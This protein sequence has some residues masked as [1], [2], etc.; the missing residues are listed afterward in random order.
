M[1]RKRKRR[2]SSIANA[3]TRA[4]VHGKK[5]ETSE[6]ERG[7]IDIWIAGEYTGWLDKETTEQIMS[8]D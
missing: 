6:N 2:T 5:I 7:K 1:A 4:I 3:L 8:R